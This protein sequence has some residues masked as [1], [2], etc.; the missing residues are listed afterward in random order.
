MPH[1][2]AHA[3]G[4]LEAVEGLE[5]RALL[6]AALKGEHVDAKESEQRAEPLQRGDGVGED[7]DAAG[8]EA[9]AQE[10]EQERVFLVARACELRLFEP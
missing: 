4:H 1:A 8:G 9:R 3:D 5:P 2:H 6:H 10:Q 7:D